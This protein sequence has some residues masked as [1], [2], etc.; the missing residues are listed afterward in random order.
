M[1]RYR[2]TPTGTRYFWSLLRNSALLEVNEVRG[3]A[4]HCAAEQSFLTE[5]MSVYGDWTSLRAEYSGR[6]RRT[7]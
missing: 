7:V 1:T 2:R 3:Q 4:K 5:S 6:L